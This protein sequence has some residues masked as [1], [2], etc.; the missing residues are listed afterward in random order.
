MRPKFTLEDVVIASWNPNCGPTALATICGLT[1]DEVR[2]LFG[3]KWPGYTN[4]TAM[5]NALRASGLQWTEI[6]PPTWPRWGLC[7][8]QWEGPWTQ[9]GV[10]IRARYRYTHWIGAARE[11]RSD[12]QG[13]WDVNALE[14]GTGWCSRE[15]WSERLA[16]VLAADH[17][18]RA[19]GDWHVT[20]AIEVHR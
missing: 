17:D 9:P 15:I 7:R 12:E 16:P 6:E 1:L 2:P 11:P 3:P 20:H 5:R 14:N 8:I 10:P 13:V 4:P 19:T 18:K